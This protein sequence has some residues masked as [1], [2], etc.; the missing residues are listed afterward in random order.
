MKLVFFK[1][2]CG[3]R[4][5]RGLALTEGDTLWKSPLL[6]KLNLFP[7]YLTCL[8]GEVLQ[9]FAFSHVATS[10][11]KSTLLFEAI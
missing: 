4:G 7:Q 9:L 1:R 3:V 5:L 6:C 8:V 2:E 11:K 10:P